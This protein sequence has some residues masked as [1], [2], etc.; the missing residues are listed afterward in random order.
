MD[1]EKVATNQHIAKLIIDAF[2][3][4]GEPLF[5]QHR[6]IEMGRNNMEFL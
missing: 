2:F 1:T 5:I 6:A 3:E 4:P